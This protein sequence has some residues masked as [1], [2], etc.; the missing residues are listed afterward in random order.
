MFL[1]WKL[2]IENW[3]LKSEIIEVLKSWSRKVKESKSRKDYDYD[4]DYDRVEES[5]SRRVEEGKS[6]FPLFCFLKTA[7]GKMKVLSDYAK[8]RDSQDEADPTRREKRSIG[9]TGLRAAGEGGMLK[10]ERGKWK[11]KNGELNELLEATQVNWRRIAR[12]ELING[13]SWTIYGNSRSHKKI[14]RSRY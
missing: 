8:R 14:T 9:F 13:N 4:D 3:K 7:S 10:V 2:K 5:K 1:N 6:N 11:T 12:R